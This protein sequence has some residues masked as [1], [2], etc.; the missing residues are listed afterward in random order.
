LVYSGIPSGGISGKNQDPDEPV[1][2][3]KTDMKPV[4]IT[5]NQKKLMRS[6]FYAPGKIALHVVSYT[7][8][9]FIGYFLKT[10]KNDDFL[11]DILTPGT[12]FT[13]VQITVRSRD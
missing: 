6:D 12:F 3:K 2:R 4:G 5:P 8:M 7:I 1:R 10:G 9:P 13:G 11:R